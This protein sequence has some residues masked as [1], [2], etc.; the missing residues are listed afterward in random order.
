ML[1]SLTPTEIL[2]VIVAYVD[3]RYAVIRLQKIIKNL[4]KE[5]SNPHLPAINPEKLPGKKAK[6]ES[7]FPWLLI[8]WLSV[9]AVFVLTGCGSTR[10]DHKQ[11]TR[12]DQST[13]KTTETDTKTVP[14]PEGP[15]VAEVV[16]KVT[17]TETL[18]H[19]QTASDGT[20][21]TTIQPPAIVSAVGD[22]A[23]GGVKAAASGSPWAP[24]VAI[25]T[26]LITAAVGAYAVKK[27]TEAKAANERA[28]EHKADAD[29][30]W[31]LVTE[32]TKEVRT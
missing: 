5:M 28:D 6:D 26:S 11:E 12:Q 17:V 20:S 3:L 7:N 15:V 31:A 29:A 8:I 4:E 18:A 30:G 13:T 23:A 19:G 32:K 21:I 1:E 24:F 10:E 22:L 25:G 27:Q 16:Q 14:G 9:G 2:V